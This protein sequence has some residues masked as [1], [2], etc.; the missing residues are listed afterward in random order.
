MFLPNSFLNQLKQLSASQ[1]SLIIYIYMH[2]YR[3]WLQF[4]EKHFNNQHVVDVYIYIYIYICV[5]EL[6]T[7]NCFRTKH[8]KQHDYIY[9]YAY[10]SNLTMKWKH[11][12][13]SSDLFCFG[14]YFQLFVNSLFTNIY[15][16][17]QC[18]VNCILYI[19]I[20]IVWQWNETHWFLRIACLLHDFLYLSVAASNLF[21]TVNIYIYI[22]IYEYLYIYICSDWIILYLYIYIVSTST[23]CMQFFEKHF[24][25]EHVVDIYIYI[26][27]LKTDDMVSDQSI[28]SNTTIYICIDI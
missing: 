8:P 7:N 11:T 21:L 9:I 25:N 4:F 28:W 26:C 2:M 14:I 18:L 27:E 5:F 24:N 6:K 16:Y 3:C 22:Y 20:Y 19:H 1:A 12:F 23:K 15:I 17:E 13:L 10:A